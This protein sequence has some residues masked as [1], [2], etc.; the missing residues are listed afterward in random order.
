MRRRLGSNLPGGA[1]TY[2]IED[3]DE[4]AQLINKDAI[5]IPLDMPFTCSGPAG[6]DEMGMLKNMIM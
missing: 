3:R 4:T 5:L 6:K 1:P 2:T